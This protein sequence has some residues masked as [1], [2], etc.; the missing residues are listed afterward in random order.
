MTALRA[1]TEMLLRAA[2]PAAALCALL[3]ATASAAP[4]KRPNLVVFLQ[5]DQDFVMGGWR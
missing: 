2:A 3:S 1:P 5:D 4:P